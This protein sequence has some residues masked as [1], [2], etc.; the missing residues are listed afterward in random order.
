[1]Y[2]HIYIYIHIH[3]HMHIQIHL[4]IYIYNSVYIYVYSYI[5]IYI[6]IYILLSWSW[7]HSNVAQCPD[8]VTRIES[9]DIPVS[10]GSLPPS[11]KQIFPLT[12]PQLVPIP[13][14]HHHPRQKCHR[15]AANTPF[16]DTPRHHIIGQYPQ[17]KPTELLVEPHLQLI[18]PHPIKNK[19]TSPR[20]G[21]SNLPWYPIVYPHTPICSPHCTS[22]HWK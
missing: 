20:Y 2:I 18:K 6:Y 3:I 17:E 11:D 14:H 21:W 1:M 16:V 13:V 4:F 19:P 5:H 15:L 10:A 9:Q 22:P 7:G 12:Y 8:T